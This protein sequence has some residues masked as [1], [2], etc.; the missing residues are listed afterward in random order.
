MFLYFATGIVNLCS[1]FSFFYA[2]YALQEK[3]F[4][5]AKI[6]MLSVA[7]TI[8]VMFIKPLPQF[9]K[10]HFGIS[11]LLTGHVIN[12][13]LNLLLLMAAGE[14]D[15]KKTM[16][17]ALFSYV[18]WFTFSLGFAGLLDLW[19]SSW[20]PSV[21]FAYLLNILFSFL[22]VGIIHL[23]IPKYDLCRIT[24]YLQNQTATYSK[25]IIL[26]LGFLF[27]TT[28]MD[29]VRSK[30]VHYSTTLFLTCLVVLVVL[31]AVL[32]STSA[33]ILL[34]DKEKMQETVIAQQNMYI[35]NL[36]EIHQN[37]RRLRHDYKNMVTSLYLQS[38]EGTLQDMEDTMG[39]I[40][41]DFDMDI[42]KKMNLTNQLANV[43]V[44]ELK[45]LLLNKITEINRLHIDFH[46]E[47]LYPVDDLIISKM[48]LIRAVGIL[49]DN[50]IEEVSGSGGD[51]SL[52]ILKEERML[53]FVIDN[54]LHHEISMAELYREG[55]TT[56]GEGRGI[57]L[58][59]YR[60]LVE[61]YDH[62]SSQTMISDG[63]L[64]QEFRIEVE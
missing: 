44:L 19:I 35:Q 43:Q 47:V 30:E 13:S 52:M 11:T 18:L 53:T 62:V 54:S 29:S 9:L 14:R 58:G 10:V 39:Q 12:L 42:G 2:Y 28:I 61:K 31:L 38:K 41:H 22:M 25:I 21:Y 64:I 8:L 16:F 46:F 63:R 33:R 24:A 15:F 34:E 59:S 27:F 7:L 49:L 1:E 48:D 3:R 45:S 36:E 40:L 4:P 57:G 50:A 6:M 51:I 26:Y 37:M 60:K 17:Y 55:Y 5:I 23:A 32:R 56:K 20:I